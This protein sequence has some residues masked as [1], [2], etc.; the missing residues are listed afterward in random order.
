MKKIKQFVR[1]SEIVMQILSFIFNIPFMVKMYIKNIRRIPNIRCLGTFLWKVSINN[2]GKNNVIVIEKAC[3]LRN[4]IINVYGDNNTII[5]ENDCELKGLNI[6]CSDGSKI[7]IKRNVHIVDNTHIASTE[8]KQI[9]IGERCLFASNTVIRNGDSHSIL[10]MDG[11][12][13]NYARD[14][15]IGDH[16]WFGQNVTVLKGTQIGKDCIVGANSV[17]SG[18]CYSDNLLIVGNPGKVVKE[19][20]TWDPR[21]SR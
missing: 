5:I 10:T 11:T 21:V 1:N 19:N 14:V 20:V 12:R 2:F 6:W 7:F 13:I 4:C 9:K 16:V 15:V 8:G 3:R 18:K 17:L